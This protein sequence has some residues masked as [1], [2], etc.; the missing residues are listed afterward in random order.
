[1][2]S[3]LSVCVCAVAEDK[4]RSKLSKR[5]HFVESSRVWMRANCSSSNMFR[6]RVI[7]LTFEHVENTHTHTS[8][9]A[10]FQLLITFTSLDQE[11]SQ[12]SIDSGLYVS[13]RA[14]CVRLCAK[15]EWKNE[16]HTTPYAA[17]IVCSHNENSNEKL[18]SAADGARNRA[19]PSTHSVSLLTSTH[20]WCI[21]C[22]C[23]MRTNN[24]SSE[25]IVRIAKQK[26]SL[27]I[28]CRYRCRVD[29][30]LFV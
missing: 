1:M 4:F 15:T 5:C 29:R 19:E 20:A 11:S 13:Q 21:T 8:T 6:T 10:A 23:R 28:M 30:V 12:F 9:L 7:H 17:A 27:I 3:L 24:G 22:E 18:N 16:K 14:R 25:L 26:Q 2:V